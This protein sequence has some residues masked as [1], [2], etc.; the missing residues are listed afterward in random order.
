MNSPV[1]LG[2]IRLVK[3]L[4]SHLVNQPSLSLFA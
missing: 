4:G 1:F 3:D 2:R